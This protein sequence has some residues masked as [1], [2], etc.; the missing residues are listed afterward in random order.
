MIIIF[1]LDDTLYQE[2]SFFKSGLR[3]VANYGYQRYG[4][5]ADESYSFMS[6]L[7]EN[8]GRDSIFNHWLI[9]HN[10][11]T[12]TTL[13]KCL[14]IYRHHIPA[15]S[16]DPEI[17]ELI[18]DLK[19]HY[20]LYLVTDGHKIVQHNKLKALNISP[21]FIKMYITHRYG[22][23]RS[24]PS[25]HCFDL[26][27]KVEKCNW[28]QMVYIGDNPNKDFVNLNKVGA[29][30][31]RVATGCHKDLV[32]APGYDAKFTISNLMELPSLMLKLF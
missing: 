21:Y 20:P 15:I 30:T 13:L 6:E 10:A 23:S 3:A 26:I 24:K 12:K 1:D 9:R 28:D 25:L 7:F 32:A 27:R 8:R 14:N 19:Q 17:M 5:C 11:L 29:H 18:E 2:A 4:W 31:I 22:I 16:L